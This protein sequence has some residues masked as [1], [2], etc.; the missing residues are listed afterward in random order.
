MTKISPDRTKK[1]MTSE[2]PELKRLQLKNCKRDRV[3]S[4][5][6]PKKK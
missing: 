5:Q 1:Q 3:L 4:A 6:V 2:T